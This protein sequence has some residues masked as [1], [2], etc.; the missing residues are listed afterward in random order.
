MVH[1]RTYDMWPHWYIINTSGHLTLKPIKPSV[2]R[3][4]KVSFRLLSRSLRR[5]R[6]T[7]GDTQ[8]PEIR[9]DVGIP[10]PQKLTSR[11]RDTS[12]EYFVVIWCRNLGSKK[13]NYTDSFAKSILHHCQLTIPANPWPAAPS[14]FGLDFARKRC[15]ALVGNCWI[16][17][18]KTLVT[19]SHYKSL[20]FL[21]DNQILT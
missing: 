12:D 10:V 14:K 8:C 6:R 20:L 17:Q 5:R 7:T 21:S 9:R 16:F 11:I 19:V 4:W 18:M 13:R 3:S 15:D 1:H 2:G